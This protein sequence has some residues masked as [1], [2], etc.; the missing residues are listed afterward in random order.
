M[1]AHNGKCI[2]SYLLHHK[3]R[4]AISFNLIQQWLKVFPIPQLSTGLA[5]LNAL[6][7]FYPNPFFHLMNESEFLFSSSA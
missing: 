2:S 1:E 7:N 5:R 4:R 3:L 6:M